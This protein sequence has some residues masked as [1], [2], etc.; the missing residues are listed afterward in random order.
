MDG[1]HDRS[2]R[3]ILRCHET[4]RLEDERWALAYD[5]ICPSVPRPGNRPQVV[6]PSTPSVSATDFSP[7]ARSA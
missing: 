6:R 3:K 1:S 4:S 7:I 5:Q 2:Q